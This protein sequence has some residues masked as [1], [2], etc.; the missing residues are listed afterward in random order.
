MKLLSRFVRKVAT[1]WNRNNSKITIPPAEAG[2]TSH[3]CP[4]IYENSRGNKRI[5]LAVVGRRVIYTWNDEKEQ[6]IRLTT[7]STK[8][9]T[10]SAG[11]KLVRA[12][13]ATEITNM[14]SRA[15]SLRSRS[16]S[17]R[18][19]KQL[20]F[21]AKRIPGLMK[22][23]SRKASRYESGADSINHNTTHALACSS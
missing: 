12:F 3:L 17:N 21:G 22:L 14:K 19:E 18:I 10:N 20:F 2:D 23:I 7:C 4:G 15:L 9:F 1:L 16:R 11:M 5:V 8:T 6:I 13:P